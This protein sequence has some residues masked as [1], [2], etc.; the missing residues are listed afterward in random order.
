MPASRLV[1]IRWQNDLAIVLQRFAK[2]LNT[3]LKYSLHIHISYRKAETT[4][5][6]ICK[7]FDL[8]ELLKESDLKLKPLLFDGDYCGRRLDHQQ[9]EERVEALSFLYGSA[10][11][12]EQPQSLRLDFPSLGCTKNLIH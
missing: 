11:R 4:F 12:A 7:A 2:F 5:I 10:E 3:R 9:T 1:K 8:I 6:L